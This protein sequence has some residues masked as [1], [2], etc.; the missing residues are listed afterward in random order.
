MRLC[1]LNVD[2]S[3]RSEISRARTTNGPDNLLFQYSLGQALAEEGNETESLDPLRRCVEG[4]PDWMA[5]RILL[6]KCLLATGQESS[7]STIL[8]DALKLAITQGH[9]EPEA[10]IR[11]LLNEIAP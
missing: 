2:G 6:G 8:R 11:E 5:P 7:A 4:K 10:E 1:H 3:S 9:E